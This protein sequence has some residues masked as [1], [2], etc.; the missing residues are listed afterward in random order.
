MKAVVCVVVLFLSLEIWAQS[1][2]VLRLHGDVF[3]NDVPV[4]AGKKLSA[5]D[6]LNA[7]GK[8]SF[9][10]VE[11]NN[12]TRF[13]LK[14]GILK[15][16]SLGELE[17]TVELKE[18]TIFTK[19]KKS[20]TGKT[21]FSVRTSKA[22]MGVR[23]TQFFIQELSDESYLCVCEG[24]VEVKKNLGSKV[25]VEKGED[26]HIKEVGELIKLPATEQMMTMGEEVFSTF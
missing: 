6:V 16:V 8:S 19:V 7:K 21:N 15:I 5:G 12:G 11:Y 18:G 14:Q 17:D 1:A 22:S 13:M 2:K 24:S 25:L 4:T 23:G 10:V 9:F 26:I 3:L 20:L